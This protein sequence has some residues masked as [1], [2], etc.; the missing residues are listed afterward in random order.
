MAKKINFIFL[1]L[2]E[3]NSTNIQVPNSRQLGKNYFLE[4]GG[5]TQAI[6]ERPF[7]P[8]PAYQKLKF[9]DIWSILS[10]KDGW[11]IF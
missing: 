5:G 4:T 8:R 6:L 1:C 3:Q 7:N 9:M 11:V 10:Y 2:A